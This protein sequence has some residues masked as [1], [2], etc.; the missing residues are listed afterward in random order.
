MNRTPSENPAKEAASQS[1]HRKVEGA[2][3]CICMKEQETCFE[4]HD[5]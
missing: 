3:G 5:V 2:E 4:M 1:E